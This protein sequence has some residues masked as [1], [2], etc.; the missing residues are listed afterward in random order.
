MFL[1]EDLSFSNVS[2]NLFSSR[3]RN[4]GIWDE[5]SISVTGVSLVWFGLHSN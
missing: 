3:D 4:T 1:L 2:D 5:V